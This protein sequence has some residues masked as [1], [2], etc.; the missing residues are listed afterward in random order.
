M[1]PNLA[2]Q[3]LEFE[4]NCK[5]DIFHYGGCGYTDI[6]VCCGALVNGLSLEL[7]KDNLKTKNGLFFFFFLKGLFLE[8]HNGLFY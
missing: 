2:I 8:F 5:L 1:A 4:Q 6:A 3:S 7:F